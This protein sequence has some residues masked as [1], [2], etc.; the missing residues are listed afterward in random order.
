MQTRDKN[1]RLQ[2]SN[3]TIGSLVAD[4]R[5]RCLRSTAS[6]NS[7]PNMRRDAD[8]QHLWRQSVLGCWPRSMEQ[9]SIAPERRW[10][11]LDC[12]V[13]YVPTNTV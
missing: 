7:E 9:S 10:I 4:A 5:E 12:A 11:G 2:I 3:K 1:A 6:N 8:I 13:F